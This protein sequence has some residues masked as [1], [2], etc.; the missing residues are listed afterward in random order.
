MCSVINHPC[1]NFKDNLAEP[2]VKLWHGWLI[3]SNNF[4]WLC[5]HAL[6]L[7]ETS[8]GSAIVEINCPKVRNGVIKG[9][10]KA[11]DIRSTS[12]PLVWATCSPTVAYPW[13]CIIQV[14]AW[15]NN[16]KITSHALKWM[17]SSWSYMLGL[18]FIHL[19]DNQWPL[20][21]QLILSFKRDDN[22]LNM[23]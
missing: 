22:M 12:L 2:P 19:V 5:I 23:L 10:I 16:M 6:K 8:N 3:T 1:Y 17:L 21:G 14:W 9:Q 13:Y 11:V 20:Q 4:M 7:V 15:I 18:D